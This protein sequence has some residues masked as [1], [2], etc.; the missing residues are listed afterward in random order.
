[1]KSKNE[2]FVFLSILIGISLGIIFMGNQKAT[3][4]FEDAALGKATVSHYATDVLGKKIHFLPKRNPANFIADIQPHLENPSILFLG[5]SQSHSINQKKDTDNTMSGF[6][7]NELI[8]DSIT[9]ITAS[10]PNAN[11]QEHHVLF[12]YFS[13]NIPNLKVLLIPMFMDDLRETGIRENYFKNFSDSSFHISGENKLQIEINKKLASFGKS[14]SDSTKTNSDFKALEKTTQEIV[15]YSINNFLNKKFSFWSNRKQI[16]GDYF[17]VLYRG[18]NSMLNISSQTTR[19]MIKSRY[20]KN[21]KALK[22]TIEKANSKGIKTI[23]LIPPIRQDIKFPYDLN[24]YK[25]FKTELSELAATQNCTLIDIDNIIE[26]KF[27][28]H[29]APTQ[30]FKD[31]DYDFMHFQS[32][33]HKIMADTLKPHILEAL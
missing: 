1:M 3:G 12:D 29:S 33:A 25:V 11:M 21:F 16:R 2:I 15:E 18:R 9:F 4:N 10:I 32:E 7:F 30:L 8:K 13:K 14:S 24:E 27:W 17:T 5:N 31:K 20:K 23:L 22:L 28:G 6:L 26:G 19:K